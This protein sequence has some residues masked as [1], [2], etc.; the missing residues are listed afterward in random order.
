MAEKVRRSAICKIVM[1]SRNVRFRFIGSCFRWFW[2]AI[3]ISG[4]SQQDRTISGAEVVSTL[5]Y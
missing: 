5:K 3:T 1:V 2:L 4:S